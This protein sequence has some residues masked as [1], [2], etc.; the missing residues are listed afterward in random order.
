MYYPF[1][2]SSMVPPCWYRMELFR[3]KAF[4]L[5]ELMDNSLPTVT[6]LR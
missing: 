2:P 1:L 6:R 4:E 5:L 3:E